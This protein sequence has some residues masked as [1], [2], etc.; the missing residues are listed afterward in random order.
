MQLYRE[1]IVSVMGYRVLFKSLYYLVK[2]AKP[3]RVFWGGVF[4]FFFFLF[5]YFFFFRYLSLKWAKAHFEV[6]EVILSSLFVAGPS[7]CCCCLWFR[8]GDSLQLSTYCFLMDLFTTCVV[9]VVFMCL[10]LLPIAKDL[11]WY[12]G[13][14]GWITA[15]GR[16]CGKSQGS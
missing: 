10:N 3:V 2:R 15:S 6:L 7:V 12:S 8:T 5:F 9:G 4:L 16:L 11:L 13:F 1:I 14:I